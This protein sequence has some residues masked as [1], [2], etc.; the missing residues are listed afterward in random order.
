LKLR[1]KDWYLQVTVIGEGADDYGTKTPLSN[2]I[3]LRLINC[4]ALQGKDKNESLMGG[5]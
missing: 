2:I 4:L 5:L 3:K 1:A